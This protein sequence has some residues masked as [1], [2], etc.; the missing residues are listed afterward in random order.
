MNDPVIDVHIH[1]GAPED[2]A[3][4]CY[5]S[6]EFESGIAFFA[7]RLVTSSL[8]RKMDIGYITKHLL[9]VINGSKRVDKCVLLAMDQVYDENGKAYDQH[10]DGKKTHLH[11]PNA[12]LAGIAR[13]NPRVLFGASVHPYRRDRED[14]LQRCLE[15]KA[16]LCKWIPSSHQI[17]LASP[18]CRPF[19]DQLAACRLPLLCHVGPEGAIP[20]FDKPSQ[21]LNSPRLLRTALDAGVTVIA[22]HAA[23]PLFPPPLESDRPYRELVS[24]F[25]E[26]GQKGWELYADLSAITLGPRGSYIDDLKRDIP[27]DRLLF[28]SDYPIPMLDVSQEPGLSVGHWLKHFFQTIFIRDPLDKNFQLIKNMDFDERLFT[29]ASRLFDRIRYS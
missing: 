22:A 11:V 7:F 24:L 16:V 8:F 26:A 9:K 6:K 2:P 12:H 15:D 3:S 4:G 23:L 17:D 5:W 1:F 19:Y 10:G 20:P 29:N 18:L 27:P 21:E 28:G 25:Q 14:E 13:Q